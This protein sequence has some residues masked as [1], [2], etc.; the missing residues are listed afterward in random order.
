MKRSFLLLSA[1][2]GLPLFIGW[3]TNNINYWNNIED[4][5]QSSWD[6]DKISNKDVF[7]KWNNLS[8]V[9][10]SWYYNDIL[11]SWEKVVYNGLFNINIPKE[12]LEREYSKR[13][14]DVS[15]TYTDRLILSDENA[16]NNFSIESYKTTSLISEICDYNSEYG[17]K[18]SSRKIMN[19]WWINVYFLNTSFFISSP[20][21]KPSM[22]YESS[23]CF[24]NNSVLYKIL[25]SS[26]VKYNQ[27][28]VNS[29]QF[30]R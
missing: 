26:N 8:W 13:Y 30:I 10:I 5:I 17:W 14:F 18:L 9:N 2:I 25:I 19:I 4:D 27:D 20:D 6:I 11:I 12:I 24:I 28:I 3:C 22:S 16:V 1:I 29:F 23:I 7:I 15:N 21:T